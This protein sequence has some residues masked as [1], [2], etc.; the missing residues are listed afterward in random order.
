[1]TSA[2]RCFVSGAVYATAPAAVVKGSAV[3]IGRLLG[4][5]RRRALVGR[6][7]ARRA[8]RGRGGARG[9]VWGVGRA[10]L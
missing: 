10:R 2:K 7:W 5:G 8:A 4:G 6:G 3:V 9:D 1:M